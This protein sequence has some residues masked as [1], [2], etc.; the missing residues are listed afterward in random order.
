MG[1]EHPYTYNLCVSDLNTLY[2]QCTYVSIGEVPCGCSEHIG[3]TLLN[4]IY[5]S[6]VETIFR[7]LFTDSDFI[8]NFNKAEKTISELMSC[9]YISGTYN[10]V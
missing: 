3:R 8:R 1:S 10:Y 5:N 2:T 9:M 4:D 6:D 7:L